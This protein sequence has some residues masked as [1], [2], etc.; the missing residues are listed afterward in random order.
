VVRQSVD[1]SSYVSKPHLL[2]SLVAVASAA[3][4]LQG[5]STVLEH[6]DA[7]LAVVLMEQTLANKVG[8]PVE[9]V[10]LS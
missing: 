1:G 10:H 2:A 7:T 5:H 8:L 6:P 3:A 4:R 9:C